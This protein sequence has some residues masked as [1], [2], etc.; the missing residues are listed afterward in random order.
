MILFYCKVCCFASRLSPR[1]V[2]HHLLRL[3]VTNYSFKWKYAVIFMASFCWMY[4][5]FTSTGKELS[6]NEY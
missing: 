1:G 6:A 4:G 2:C 3:Y 5:T